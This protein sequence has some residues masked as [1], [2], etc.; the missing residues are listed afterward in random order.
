MQS[1]HTKLCVSVMCCVTMPL[2][3]T[4][5][6]NQADT[7][8][9]T[10]FQ[11]NSDCLPRYFIGVSVIKDPILTT[12]PIHFN[13]VCYHGAVILTVP[14]GYVRRAHNLRAT[15]TTARNEMEVAIVCGLTLQELCCC[16]LSSPS[17]PRF[18]HWLHCNI[19]FHVSTC[20]HA[21]SDHVR[22]RFPRQP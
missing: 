21:S 6:E 10:P 17:N 18:N 9:A 7:R 19:C 3:N 22:R 1:S 8:P 11:E 4:H 15:A 5:K 20:D 12:S 14:N 16:L 13:H 2:Q